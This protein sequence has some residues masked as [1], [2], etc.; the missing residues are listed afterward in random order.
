AIAQAQ[1]LAG[2]TPQDITYVEAHGTGTRLGDPV[3]FSALSQ[4]FAGASQKQYCALGSVKTNIGH[5]D[6]AAGVAGL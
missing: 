3:E 5:L 1:R 2:L 6:T 4:A